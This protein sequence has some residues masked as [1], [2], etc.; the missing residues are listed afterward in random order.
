MNW[1]KEAVNDLKT[2]QERVQGSISIS[3]RIKILEE[4]Y[5]TLKGVSS[6]EP[7]MGGTSKQEDKLIN[8]IDERERLKAALNE[9]NRLIKLTDNALNSLSDKD[10][11]I[12]EMFFINRPHNYKDILCE[13][14]HVEE[15]Q[16]YR[17]KDAALKK[18]TI[19]MYGIVEI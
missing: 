18:Y 10:K 14:F 12:L 3:E 17:M 4:R 6:G 11:F 5:I 13:K 9:V 2:Y 7:V 19:A 8:N 1:Q 15:A 16:I